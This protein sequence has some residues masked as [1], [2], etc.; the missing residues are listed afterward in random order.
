MGVRLLLLTGIVA[1]SQPGCDLN[2]LGRIDLL[3][4]ID[5]MYFDLE[6]PTAV[7][8]DAEVDKVLDEWQKHRAG[9][10]SLYVEFS[11]TVNDKAFHTVRRNS[12]S[13][14]YSH[15]NLGRME[16]LKDEKGKVPRVFI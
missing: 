10:K 11:R 14:R 3:G 4:H 7:P 12:G 1:A 16:V 8:V 9:Q 6:Q 2:L 15:P 13:M 5:H